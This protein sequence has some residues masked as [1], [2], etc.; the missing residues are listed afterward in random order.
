MI[1]PCEF[2]Q[3]ARQS[4][5]KVHFLFVILQIKNTD[6]SI[7]IERKFLIRSEDYKKSARKKSYIS[8]AYLS[9]NPEATVRVRVAN[10]KAYLT[11]K[12]KS[13]AN[14]TNRY[15]WEKEI[16]LEEAAA[17]MKLCAGKLIEKYRY[18]VEYGG[19]QFEV[20][21]F[22]GENFGLVVAEIELE[23]AD[24]PFEKPPWLGEEVT[25]D[26]AYFNASLTE[27]PYNKW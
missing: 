3:F 24:E 14:N 4:T 13:F 16:A 25:A 22:L 19:K 15:E 7:E 5:A 20:D 12:G 8:Q 18:L 17:L 21:E 6:M 27:K 1:Y 2:L 10:E 9:I 23:H 26:N 11:I